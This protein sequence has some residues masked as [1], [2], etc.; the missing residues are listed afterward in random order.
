MSFQ[1]TYLYQFWPSGNSDTDDHP[2]D[3]RKA[4]VLKKG[5]GDD[6]KMWIDCHCRPLLVY[7]CIFVIYFLDKRECECVCVH[8]GRGPQNCRHTTA[9]QRVC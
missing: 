7:Y 2:G 1:K 9:Y 5:I 3:I 6:C 8:V 4:N